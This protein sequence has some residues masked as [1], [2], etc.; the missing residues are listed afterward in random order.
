MW[1]RLMS[2]PSGHPPRQRN[3]LFPGIPPNTPTTPTPAIPSNSSKPRSGHRKLIRRRLDS[4]VSHILAELKPDLALPGLGAPMRVAEGRG[5]ISPEQYA[6][7]PPPPSLSP[8]NGKPYICVA[9]LENVAS[10]PDSLN[11]RWPPHCHSSGAHICTCIGFQRIRIFRENP[12]G[13]ARIGCPMSPWR[14]STLSV[15]WHR[16]CNMG[17]GKL[18]V[19][20]QM[21]G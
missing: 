15:T 14:A 10:L 16:R 7:T 11:V 17:P 13:A 6:N 5:G 18:R 20:T 3:P 9:P 12:G 8:T 19:Y 2:R 21:Y 1:P 4:E